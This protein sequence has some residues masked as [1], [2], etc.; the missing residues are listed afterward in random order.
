MNENVVTVEAEEIRIAREEGTRTVLALVVS[1][2]GM[3]L[4]WVA[5]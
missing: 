4:L 5:L 3:L 2:L 1:A